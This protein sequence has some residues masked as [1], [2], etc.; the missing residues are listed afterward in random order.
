[1]EVPKSL[2]RKKERTN[3]GRIEVLQKYRKENGLYT[4]CRW[5]KKIETV[6]SLG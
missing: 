5:L 2:I 3:F 6:V 4:W 1:M